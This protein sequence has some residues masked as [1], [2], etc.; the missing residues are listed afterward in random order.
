MLAKVMEPYIGDAEDFTDAV[1]GH[2]NGFGGDSREE[3]VIRATLGNGRQHGLSEGVK[4][5][6]LRLIVFGRGE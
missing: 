5:D 6:F 4:V 2:A 1:K 3:Q